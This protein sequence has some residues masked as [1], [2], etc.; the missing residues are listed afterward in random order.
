MD[1][2]S[3][4]PRQVSTFS[5]NSPQGIFTEDGGSASTL[6]SP[7]GFATAHQ[8]ALWFGCSFLPDGLPVAALPN[9]PCLVPAPVNNE[10]SS[11]AVA[12]LWHEK[13]PEKHWYR[14]SSYAKQINWNYVEW[15]SKFTHC[16]TVTLLLVKRLS[17]Q[18]DSVWWGFKNLRRKRICTI[19]IQNLHHWTNKAFQ[20]NRI[21]YRKTTENVCRS[22]S[23]SYWWIACEAHSKKLGRENIRN[24]EYAVA[25]FTEHPSFG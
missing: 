16:Y 5:R 15:K 10:F 3:R 6:A 8:S 22:F 21:C 24:I 17:F 1:T 13:E 7:C 19:T 14:S 4:A 12:G 9:C 2:I 11:P 23:T 20:K 18:V 25:A